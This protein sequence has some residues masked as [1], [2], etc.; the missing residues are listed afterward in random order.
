MLRSESSFY[1]WVQTISIF[2]QKALTFIKNAACIML[3]SELTLLELVLK[4]KSALV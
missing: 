4:Q 3:D 2:I 1:V